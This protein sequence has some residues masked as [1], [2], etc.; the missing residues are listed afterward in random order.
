LS[1]RQAEAQNNFN[2]EINNFRQVGIYL[3]VM[4]FSKQIKSLKQVLIN[5]SIF[6]LHN[7][8]F[9]FTPAEKDRLGFYLDNK[10]T[11]GKLYERNL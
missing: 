2:L 3:V 5:S 4:V 11:F 10:E 6:Y 1:L 8:L 9:G 7:L